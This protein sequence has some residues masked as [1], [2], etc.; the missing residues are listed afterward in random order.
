MK[1]Q[2]GFVGAESINR[3]PYMSLH[4]FDKTSSLLSKYVESCL[5][6]S[7]SMIS[8]ILTV[9]MELLLQFLWFNSYDLPSISMIS[10]ILTVFT[11]ISELIQCQVLR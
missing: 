8:T 9:F 11:K 3:L 7:I 1:S 2:S 5:L 6:P 10:I 4:S